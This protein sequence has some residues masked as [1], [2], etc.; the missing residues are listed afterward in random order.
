M[1]NDS[2]KW[3]LILGASSGFGAA[4]A[5]AL[6]DAGFDVAGVH[7]DRRATLPNAEAVADGI[8]AKGRDALFFNV[9]AADP[10]RRAEVVATCREAGADI[11]VMLHSLAFGTLKPYVWPGVA[12]GEA[13]AVVRPA[14]MD[15]T[16]SV[17]AH[18][19]VWW[20]QDLLAAGLLARGAQLYVMTSAGNHRVSPAYGPVSAAKAALEA[21]VRQLAV[22]LAPAGVAVNAIQAGVTDTP[23]AR[24]I[25]GSEA[26]FAS[27]LASNPGGRL[28]TPADVAALIAALAACDAATWMTGNVLRV[29]GGE[30]LVCPPHPRLLQPAPSRQ[31][32]S[33]TCRQ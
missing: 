11:R 10:E 20:A 18:S 28:T 3:A 26:L 16:L 2:K 30:D 25:P 1:A 7:L 8:R 5:L 29:D 9:N 14:D 32:P 6:A 23:A 27:A 17:M 4:T 22:E 13:G 19:L 15:M 21:H 12:T 24:R 33:Y 31:P